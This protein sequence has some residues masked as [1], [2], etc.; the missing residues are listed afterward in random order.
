MTFDFGDPVDFEMIR[1]LS[2]AHRVIHIKPSPKCDVHYPH[3][4]FNEVI[5][6]KESLHL[7]LRIE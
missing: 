1:L 6:L 2:V 5:F 4:T 3:S 7:E